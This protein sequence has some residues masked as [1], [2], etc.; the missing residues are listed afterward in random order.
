MVWRDVTRDYP[1]LCALPVAAATADRFVRA[2]AVMDH[3]YPQP[4][5]ETV[6][7][8]LCKQLADPRPADLDAVDL[9]VHRGIQAP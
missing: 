2:I 6:T 9:T 3:L 4:G 8:Q 1:D 5:A 7:R